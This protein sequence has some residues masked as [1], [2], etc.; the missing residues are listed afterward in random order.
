MNEDIKITV[1]VKKLKENAICIIFNEYR[2]LIDID[3]FRVF[4]ESENWEYI[5][6]FL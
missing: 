6:K 4:L 3:L 1:P 5:L 2:T